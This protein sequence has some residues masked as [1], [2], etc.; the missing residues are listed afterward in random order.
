MGQGFSGSLVE[1]LL[2]VVIVHICRR[3]SVRSRREPPFFFSFF[4]SFAF[5]GEGEREEEGGGYFMYV[6]GR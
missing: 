1:F 4:V 6:V 2:W 5:L 3:S